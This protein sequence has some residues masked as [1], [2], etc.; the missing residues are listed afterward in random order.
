MTHDD[1]NTA[2]APKVAGTWNLHNV[3]QAVPLDFF[4]LFSS[5]VAL[6]GNI[7]QANYA[8]ANTF[9]DS[10]VGYRHSKGL[11]ASVINLGFMQDIGFVSQNPKLLEL[12]LSIS[13]QMLDEQDLLSALQ[14]ACSQPMSHGESLAIGLGS[15]KP[16]SDPGVRPLW[17]RDARFSLYKN[18][19]SPTEKGPNIG[20]EDLKEF[21]GAIE[22][23][24]ALLDEKS[25]E[26]LVTKELG[27]LVGSYMSASEEMDSSQVAIIAIDSLM[28]IEIRSWVRRNL[29]L[30]I[31]LVEISSA[32]TV[33]GL[34]KT[35]IKALR[36]KYQP[37]PEGEIEKDQNS[38][39]GV[40]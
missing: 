4:V 14:L 28:C 9:L 11:P 40:E 33:G 35:T 18:L 20:S 34:T 10:F 22:R 23:N 13:L 17:A 1:W 27:K 12:A 19:E 24:P 26:D 5:V 16:L 29:G 37:K 39:D 8:A 25:T 7:G 38:P 30:D 32:G 3:L 36:A 6:G 21:I 31:T 2:L 15:N